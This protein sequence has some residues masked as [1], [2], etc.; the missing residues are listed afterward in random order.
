MRA[1]G[2]IFYRVKRK[3]KNRLQVKQHGG[4]SRGSDTGSEITCPKRKKGKGARG[5]GFIVERTSELKQ[6]ICKRTQ[7]QGWRSGKKKG[8]WLIINVR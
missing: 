8:E 7:S 5:I 3:T 1:G 6:K 4:M 2:R